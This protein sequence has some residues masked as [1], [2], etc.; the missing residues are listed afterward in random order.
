VLRAKT[1]FRRFTLPRV[2]GG[3]RRGQKFVLGAFAFAAAVWF[4][5]TC[6]ALDVPSYS[7]FVNDTAGMLSPAYR[8]AL[9][10]DL[11]AYEASTT[12]EIAVLTVPTLAGDSIEDFSVRVFEQWGIG[13]KSQ[14]NGLLLLLVRDDKKARIEIGYGLEPYITDADAGDII[15]NDIAPAFQAGKYDEGVAAAIADVENYLGGNVV[16]QGSQQGQQDEIGT[17]IF[18]SLFIVSII[19]N[20]LRAR[21]RKK[22]LPIPWWWAGGPP[23]GGWGGGFGGFGGGR[24]G[25][26]G[27]SGGW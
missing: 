25:G 19:L 27:A 5:T 11:R 9:E 1:N 24:S 14:D 8:V 15:R 3:L 21:R 26:G 12:N 23:T 4:S 18:F 16:A 22:G 7:G 13:K 20:I 17:Y 2:R 10:Q 6:H